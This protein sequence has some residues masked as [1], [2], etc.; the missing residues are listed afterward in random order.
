MSCTK[1]SLYIKN[2]TFIS[3]QVI[4][5]FQRFKGLEETKNQNTSCGEINVL[6]LIYICYI[7][8]YIFVYIYLYVL[9]MCYLQ[10]GTSV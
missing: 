10:F 2:K 8:V 5:W 4:F 9:Y 3:P 7:F 6:F 1:M